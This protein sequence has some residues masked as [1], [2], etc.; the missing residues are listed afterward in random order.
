MEKIPPKSSKEWSDLVSGKLEVKL[1]NYFFQMK[2]TDAKKKFKEGTISLAEATD[3]IYNL[4]LKYHKAIN[5][6]EDLQKIFKVELDP[7]TRTL[8]F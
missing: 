1:T 2:L 7:K 3:D 5:M 4:C 8:I 6:P